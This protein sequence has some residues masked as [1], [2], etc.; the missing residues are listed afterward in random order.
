MATARSSASVPISAAERGD[1]DA[2]RSFL[3]TSQSA[4][5]AVAIDS[6]GR[7]STLLHAAARN[8]QRNIVSL[9]IEYDCRV[10]TPQEGTDD[11]PL[12]LALTGGHEDV[13]EELLNHE[14][15]HYNAQNSAGWSALM[16]AAQSGL[17]SAMDQLLMKGPDMELETHEDRETAL[18]L[19]VAAGQDEAVKMLVEF[20]AQTGHMNGRG[21][22]PLDLAWQ[23]RDEQSGRPTE[24]GYKRRIIEALSERRRRRRRRA[25]ADDAS[26]DDLSADDAE[27]RSGRSSGSSSRLIAGRYKNLGQLGSGAHG[28]ALLVRD[29]RCNRGGH[30]PDSRLKVLKQISRQTGRDLQA[31]GRENREL[32]SLRQLDHSCLLSLLDYFNDT[33]DKLC[34]VTE[35]CELR[36]MHTWIQWA[37]NTDI[38]LPFRL[39]THWCLQMLLG[40]SYLHER[41]IVHG[42]FKPSNVFVQSDATVRIGDFGCSLDLGDAEEAV[43]S[44]ISGTWIYMSPEMI[45][46]NVRSTANDMW[47]LGCTFYELCTCQPLFDP[48]LPRPALR[49]QICSEAERRF[50]ELPQLLPAWLHA[51]LPRMLR[52][53]PPSERPTAAGLLLEDEVANS[54]RKM[55]PDQLAEDRQFLADNLAGVLEAGDDNDAAKYSPNRGFDYSLAYDA[56]L[57]DVERFVASSDADQQLSD[58][59]QLEN[60]R[61]KL[62]E[63]KNQAEFPL[64]K[65]YQIFTEQNVEQGTGTR[66]AVARSGQQLEQRMAELTSDAEGCEMVQMAILL[67]RQCLDS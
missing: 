32:L 35:Y 13:A 7:R 51:A 50:D 65:V 17:V 3:N 8:G 63:K 22:T 28:L 1:Y 39:V 41:Q 60:L 42:D 48:G 66:S 29:M 49:A 26:D 37:N 21:F 62:A 2:V 47:S 52:Q 27:D 64:E 33:D 6:A 43:A 4:S 55:Q 19:A 36:D 40:L 24:G 5:N 38:A 61:A 12:M 16:I 44:A 67:E 57:A 11:T 14:K 15:C 58:Y 23:L 56:L 18:T 46:N 10:N 34:L 59:Q 25:E 53:S 30:G 31:S 9:L 20:G 54:L 45:Q